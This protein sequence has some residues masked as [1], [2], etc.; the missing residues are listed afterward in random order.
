MT[1]R[2]HAYQAIYRHRV[3]VGRVLDVPTLACPEVL[4]QPLYILTGDA[5]FG[6]RHQTSAAWWASIDWALVRRRRHH[7]LGSEPV[8]R[9][10]RCSWRPTKKNRYREGNRRRRHRARS[11]RLDLE[12]SER[13]DEVICSGRPYA[14]DNQAPLRRCHDS[15][16]RAQAPV[17]SD[18]ARADGGGALA[19]A[20][21]SELARAAAVSLHCRFTDR[22][23]SAVLSLKGPLIARSIGLLAVACVGAAVVALN[24]ESH[25]PHWPL[26]PSFHFYTLGVILSVV[27]LVLSRLTRPPGR[28]AGPATIVLALSVVIAVV[29]VFILTQP[30][31]GE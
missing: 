25:R 27:S 9:D 29:L 3:R 7:P 8:H 2:S 6:V 22:S 18:R 16:A 26:W 19:L 23:T 20:A 12:G 14:Y 1:R 24:V 28:G 17:G 5:D 13:F 10:S 30:K 31:G 4:N 15:E 11:M 21:A